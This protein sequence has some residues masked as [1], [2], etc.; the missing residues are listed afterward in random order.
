MLPHVAPEVA[1]GLW[2]HGGLHLPRTLFPRPRHPGGALLF[3]GP[4]PAVV[5]REEQKIRRG[6]AQDTGADTPSRLSPC[7]Q[8]REP[9][10]E[11]PQGTP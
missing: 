10:C 11:V 5:F 8:G 1:S 6:W 9:G 7:M 2:V 4:V 3:S